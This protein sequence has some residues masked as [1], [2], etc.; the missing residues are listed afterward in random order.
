MSSGVNCTNDDKG[1]IGSC[2]G[3]VC[4]VE[5]AGGGGGGEVGGGGGEVDTARGGEGEGEVD[6]APSS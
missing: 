1:G 5:E 4:T 3:S 2:T 6:T